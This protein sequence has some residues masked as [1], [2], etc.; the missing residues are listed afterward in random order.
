MR[1]LYFVLTSAILISA[2]SGMTRASEFP[3][4]VVSCGRP[5]TYEAAPKRAVV[6]DLNMAEIMFALELQSRMAGLTGITGWYKTTPEFDAARGDLPELAS[7]NPTVENILSADPD[8]FFSGWYYGMNP[9]GEVTPETLAAFDIPVYVLTESCV[10]LDKNRPGVSLETLYRDVRNI[11]AIFGVAERADALIASWKARVAR[12]E[13]VTNDRK[14]VRV[15]LY[16]SGDEKPF[17]A[18]RFAMPT[19]LIEAAGGVNIMQDVETSW[20]SVAW[21]SVGDRNPEFIILLDY[22]DGGQGLIDFLE[23]HPLMSETDAV[24]HRRYLPL[25]YGEITPGP[26]NIQ[27]IEKLAKAYDS[28]GF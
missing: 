22:G 15:F 20:G 12:I 26:A 2:L 5:H 13:T 21:E 24:K 10:H 1:A 17:T 27:A 18:G 9:G 6:H 3:V 16:D 23:A 28:N 8:F 19:A 7:K 25:K 14:A 4:T 11:A